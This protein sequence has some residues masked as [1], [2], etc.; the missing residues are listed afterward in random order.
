MRFKMEEALDASVPMR[1]SRKAAYVLPTLFT[2][3][4]I[5]LGFLAIVKTIQGALFAMGGDLGHNI[6]FEVAAPLGHHIVSQVLL[7]T[8]SQ[9]IQ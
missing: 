6:H 3:G 2:A 8:W 9:Q 5:F 7:S 1:R 4:N